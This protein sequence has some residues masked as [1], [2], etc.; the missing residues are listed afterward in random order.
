M[1]TNK[2]AALFLCNFAILFIGFGLFPLLPVHAAE[3]GATPAQVGVY[4]AVTYIAITLGNLLTGWLSGRISRKA[5]F[6]IAGL[7]GV[8]ALFLLGQVTVL[9]QMIVLT[10]VVW[11]TGGIGLALVSVFVGL[12][13]SEANRGRWFGLIALTNPLGAVIGGSVVA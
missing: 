4:L 1:K 10:S 5:L 11:F 13:A 12:T 8:P 9:W 3:L 6:V 2:L 7:V